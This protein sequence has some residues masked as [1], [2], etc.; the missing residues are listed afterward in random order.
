MFDSEAPYTLRSIQ[1]MLGISRGVITQLIQAG[2]VLPRRGPRNEYRFGFRDIVLLRTA[3]ALRAADIAPRKIIA[4]LRRLKASLPEELPLTGLRITAVGDR[5]AVREGARQWEA[6]SGQLLM[7]FEISPASGSVTVLERTDPVTGQHERE[8]PDELLALGVA[9]EERDKE[10]AE[11]A[12]RRAIDV[13]PDRPD[14]YLNL[15]AMLCE[16]GRCDEAVAL[17]D[18]A[19][20]RCPDEPLVHFNRAI[21]FEDR[22]RFEESLAS[23]ERCLHLAPK[24]ADAHYNLASLWEQLGNPQK[25]LRHLSAYRRLQR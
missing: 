6:D 10:A 24:L 2:F 25:A 14:A 22:G 21:A 7:D 3:Y 1:E 19:V 5:V 4:S 12:Y 23:Y 13:A 17:Y 9:L 18:R 16:A 20:D 8:D 11:A 15:G